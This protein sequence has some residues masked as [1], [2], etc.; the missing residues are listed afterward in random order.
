MFTNG[1]Y[2]YAVSRKIVDIFHRV[3]PHIPLPS[4]LLRLFERRFR[5]VM[6]LKFAFI[7]YVWKLKYK[8]ANIFV[9]Y[10]HHRKK[11]SLLVRKFALWLLCVLC[12]NMFDC[13]LGLVLIS[14][15][16]QRFIFDFVESIPFFPVSCQLYKIEEIF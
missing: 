16:H 14:H 9:P 15:S 13:V 3:S 5:K 11:N 1:I 7:L 10:T 2:H 8:L 12:E 4:Y 6:F